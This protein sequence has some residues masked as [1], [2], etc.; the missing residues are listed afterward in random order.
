MDSLVQ[1]VVSPPLSISLFCEGIR[2]S[3][4]S[5]SVWC[6]QWCLTDLFLY[7]GGLIRWLLLEIGGRKQL[8]P[9]GFVLPNFPDI[10]GVRL[11]PHA[12][13]H[14]ELLS[15][16]N[17]PRNYASFARLLPPFLFR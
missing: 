16:P 13:R 12:R 4:R 7:S 9:Q 6:A 5:G 10:L 15:L 14:C 11:N 8:V 1:G 3:L 2:I 17:C